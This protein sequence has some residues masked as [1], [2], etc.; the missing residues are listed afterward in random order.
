LGR[1]ADGGTFSWLL[2]GA[3][4][5]PQVRYRINLSKDYEVQYWSEKFGV[6]PEQL[7]DAV[8]K[9]RKQKTAR[10]ACSSLK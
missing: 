3:K 7:R 2:K 10:F 6:T 4:R 9:V 5:G 8:H 1:L